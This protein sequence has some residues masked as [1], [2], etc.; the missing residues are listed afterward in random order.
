M[1]ALMKKYKHRVVALFGSA[2]SYPTGVIDPIA[3]L[4]ALAIK[5]E[6]GLHVDCCLGHPNNKPH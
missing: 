6:C 4:S 2:P 1:E 3:K 5:Y